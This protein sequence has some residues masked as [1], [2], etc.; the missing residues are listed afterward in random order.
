MIRGVQQCVWPSGKQGHACKISNV[1]SIGIWIQS[2]SK[3]SYRNDLGCSAKGLWEM[4][5]GTSDSNL[6]TLN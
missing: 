4:C 3:L 1:Q 5:V 6:D 2:R